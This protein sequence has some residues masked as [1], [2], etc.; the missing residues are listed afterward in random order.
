MAGILCT[1]PT[2]LPQ[3]GDPAHAICGKTGDCGNFAT[4][5][6]QTTVLGKIWGLKFIMPLQLSGKMWD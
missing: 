1:G 4:E 3:G 5:Q 2:R 6:I